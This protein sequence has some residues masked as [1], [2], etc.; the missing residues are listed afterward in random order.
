MRYPKCYA[1][2]G[3]AA[4]AFHVMWDKNNRHCY[5]GSRLSQGAASWHTAH[6]TRHLTLL[7]LPARPTQEGPHCSCNLFCLLV[8]LLCLGLGHACSASRGRR[9]RVSSDPQCIHC[10][11]AASEKSESTHGKPG[12]V[13]SSGPTL[14]L[15]WKK[16]R[17][18][19]GCC[20]LGCRTK[21]R[22]LAQAGSALA[23]NHPS[24]ASSQF[25]ND[26]A[27]CKTL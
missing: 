7:S 4:D 13:P 2:W 16:A 20:T 6:H 12:R 22:P 25:T 27:S 26:S 8:G 17:L 21:A 10:E 9:P 23:S 15:P 3:E 5:V 14:W 19:G 24:P 11:Q 1:N 18:S